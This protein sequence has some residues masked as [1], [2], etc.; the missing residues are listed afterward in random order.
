MSIARND[1]RTTS[2]HFGLAWTAVVS[3]FLP[4]GTLADDQG[5]IEEIVVTG[6]LIKRDNFDSASPLQVLD[7]VDLQ[8][9][10][11]PALGEIVANQTF[12]Y[13]TDVFASHYSVTNPEGN[14]SSANFRGLGEGATLALL[15]GKRV[16]DSNLNNLIPQ[17]AIARVDILKD[18]ASAL[19][20]SDAVAG[21]INVVSK[22]NVNGAEIGVFYNMDSEGDHDEYVANFLIG[23]RTDRGYFTFATEVREKTALFQTERPDITNQSVSSSDSGNPGV[24][25][26]PI[27]GPNGLILASNLKDDQNNAIPNVETLVD[28]GCGIA[29]SPGGN[30]P[31]VGGM[32]RNNLSGRVS[33]NVCLF[34]FGEFFNFVT[35]NKT[36]NSYLNYEYR[37]NDQ[38]TYEGSFIYSR[39]RNKS[40]GA[41]SNPGGRI[42]DINNL[43]GGISGDHPG[44]PYRA[45]YDANDNGLIDTGEHL[46]AADVNGDKVPDRNTDG[47]VVLAADP[48][49]A[50]QGIPFN[51]DVKIADLR[52]FG[53]MGVRPSNL[54]E[55]GANLGY[56]TYDI[57]QIRMTHEFTYS[58]DNGW[59]VAAS[60]LMMQT[61]DIR[62]RKNGSF[63]A[64]LLGL[65]GELGPAPGVS[66]LREDQDGD[67]VVAMQWY[68]PFATNALNCADRVCTDP[69]VAANDNLGDYPNTQFVADSIDI[70][71]LRRWQSKLTSIELLTTGDLLE[72]RTGSVGAAFG[73]EWRQYNAE[74]DARSDENQCNNWYDACGG[75]YSAKDKNVSF[76][77]EFAVPFVD[78]SFYGYGEL[79]LAGRYSDYSGIGSS[80]DPK[81]AAL[82]QPLTWLSFRASY[83]EAFI[84]PTIEQRF[85]PISSFLQ[86]TN[87]FLLNDFEGTYRTNTFQ[88]NQDLRPETAKISNFGV[89]LTFLEGDLNFGLDYSNFDFKDRITL[90]TGPRVVDQDFKKFLQAYPNT[91]ACDPCK[92]GQGYAVNRSDAIAWINGTDTDSSIIRNEGP[93]YTIVNIN[94]YYLNANAMQHS[95]FDF[96]ANYSIDTNNLGSFRFDLSATQI[97]EYSFDF[98]G[99]NKGKAVG[100]QNLDIDVIPPLPKMRVIGSINWNFGDQALL[101]R[102]RW[103]D[104]VDATKVDA[105]IESLTYIDLTY[106]F[107]GFDWTS[108][109]SMTTFEIGARNLT[110][111]YP[112][113]DGGF[114]AGIELALHDP[115]GRMFFGRVK[116]E[117]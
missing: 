49:D 109:G 114:G 15:D 35:P 53:K 25:D 20:G 9:E 3:L 79:Q 92:D 113:P 17:I 110:D 54:D 19:Y 107:T 27:R 2:S 52:L 60:G 108:K 28:P 39:Q 42:R 36:I 117:F 101:L 98:G 56:A 8:A 66:D 6:S 31:N 40:R 33:E 95:A 82:Y 104:E 22:K 26:V 112:R 13:G 7:D 51:E 37:I 99:D 74:W 30:G 41:P 106:A 87:D 84:A 105:V 50:S 71:A 65:Q 78:D 85:T 55:T 5:E 91:P 68:N 77:Y 24:Y 83:S 12:N 62:N 18:G 63:R 94:A 21:V 90:L 75:D 97:D 115:R 10:A 80:F 59:E 38:F 69:G 46:F 57:N 1:R 96:Y 76:Y 43:L 29:A 4:F 67:G 70:N 23:D 32:V 14:R 11:T 58:F 16:T 103:A 45:F 44:N 61:N 72:L 47:E 88:G 34:E 93:S 89:S 100:K 116:H 73:A 86:S 64:V 111:E 81:Y 48:F 102:A